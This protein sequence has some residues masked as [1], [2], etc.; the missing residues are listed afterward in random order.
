MKV[1]LI[2]VSAFTF[3]LTSCH[4]PIQEDIKSRPIATKAN[5][6]NKPALPVA[7]GS[8]APKTW[9][10]WA[11]WADGI[12]AVDDGQGH[13]PDVGS[14]EWARALDHQLNISDKSGHGPD[15]S[16]SEWRGAVERILHKR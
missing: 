16:S 14:E 15:L 10:A 11:L 8:V 5:D 1:I 12:H 7:T 4:P 3:I 13:G 6:P 2:S 9:N